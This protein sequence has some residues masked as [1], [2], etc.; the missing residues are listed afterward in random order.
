MF[1]TTEDC[2]QGFEKK[3]ATL[4]EQNGS[5][6]MFVVPELLESADEPGKSKSA[7]D[8]YVLAGRK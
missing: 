8:D 2:G 6:P 3:E 7:I 5:C 1:I 4:G